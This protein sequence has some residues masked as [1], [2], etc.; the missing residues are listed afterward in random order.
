MRWHLERAWATLTYRDHDAL[1]PDERDPVTPA[2]RSDAATM[3][4][5]SH[6]TPTGEGVH[7]FTT[8]LESL[9][10][11]VRN[12]HQHHDTGATITL[13]TIPTPHQRHAL[14]LLETINP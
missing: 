14:E 10:T 1:D 11:I 3:K 2:R 8:L 12:T 6:T 13:D 9:G 5:A 4:A 7:S